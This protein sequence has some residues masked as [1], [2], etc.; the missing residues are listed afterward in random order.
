MAPG[1]SRSSM[2]RGIADVENAQ[3][4]WLR[5]RFVSLFISTLYPLSRSMTDLQ[6]VL[7]LSVSLSSS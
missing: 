2:R 4:A 3:P 7:K 1:Q 6:Q 5:V